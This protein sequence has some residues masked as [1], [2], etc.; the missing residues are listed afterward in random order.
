[1]R[2]G[3]TSWHAVAIVSAFVLP[4]FFF[5]PL[6]VFLNNTFEFSLTLSQVFWIFL[7]VAVGLIAVLY[8]LTRRW[9]QVF[10]PAMTCL[11]VV[12]FLESKIF[13]G[14]A[15]HRPFDGQLIDWAQF[16]TLS[17]AEL[18]TAAMVAVLVVVFRRRQEIWYSVALFILLFHVFGLGY[19]VF[20]RPNALQQVR[21]SEVRANVQRNSYFSEFYRL[22]KERNVIH[23]VP[24][25]TP[26]H[27]VYEIINDDLERY[28]QAFDGFTLFTNAMG[29]YP[30]TYPSVT[31]YMTGRAPE[32]RTDV[33]ASVPFTQ[34][35][36][37][38]ILTEHSIVNTLAANGF[39]TF[40]YQVR[41]AYCAGK[42]TACIAEN[43]FQ[44]A[45]ASQIREQ[46][47]RRSVLQLLDISL[48]QVTPIVIRRRIY[49]DQRW[50]LSQTIEQTGTISGVLDVFIDRLTTEEIAG[51]YNYIH[52]HGGHPPV[53]F[54][55]YC[56]YVGTV[57]WAYEAVREQVK[58][59]LLQ[60]QR[61]VEKLKKAG[62]FD[63]TL[64]IVGADHG[65]MSLSPPMGPR[66]ETVAFP[67]MASSADLTLLV[68]PVGVRG[69][70]K[71]ST[72]PASNG[73]IP[74]TINDALGLNGTFPGLP[75]LGINES[76]PRLREFI[77]YQIP[78]AEIA[79][80][81]TGKLSN[82]TRFYN[83]GDVFNRDDWIIPTPAHLEDAPSTLTMDHADFPRLTVGFSISENGNIKARWIEGTLARV[84]LSFPAG[85]KARLVLDSYVPP[86][87]PGQSV[88]IS[89]NERV[90]ARLDDKELAARRR[91]VIP[92]P[93]SV[94]RKKVNTVELKMG[95][96][97][98]SQTGSRV[99]SIVVIYIGLEPVE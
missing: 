29:R 20:S 3:G 63:Q 94:P 39:R 44:P 54:D 34:E 87:I 56:N 85:D 76:D 83:R 12:V 60:L 15:E 37:R 75:V 27:M 38:T 70:L 46:G 48:F 97:V 35:Y 5:G 91:H 66:T 71:F 41:D 99:F 42:F 25:G 53:Q 52:H 78:S 81:R 65:N 1:M 95:K 40:G 31:F 11:S 24:D 7:I 10:L 57:P 28:S 8:L 43:V 36:I 88:E 47:L 2:T 58:C 82:V 23:I 89:I 61:L 62:V 30:R 55:E 17:A 67:R 69:P 90:I 32:L 73:D 93:D 49:D 74:A 4:V 21:A 50:L 59:T 79:E 6:Q 64:I 96:A 51:S 98:R 68:K 84:Y 9:H 14:L 22:S 72:A 26:G 33:S 13:L 45:S 77:W 16:R 18:A 86:S 80:A 92:V 19:T